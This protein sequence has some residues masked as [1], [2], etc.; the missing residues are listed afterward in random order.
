MNKFYLILVVLLTLTNTRIAA[1]VT[2][3]PT[4]VFFENNF[5]SMIIINTSNISQD[6]LVDFIFGYPISDSLGNV[7]M[8]YNRM[9]DLARYD[10]SGY[11][12]AFP[13]AITLDPGQRQ[14]VRLNIRPPNDLVES[15]YWT[16]IKVTSTPQIQDIAETDESGVQTQLNFIFEQIIPLYFRRGSVKTE[17]SLSDLSV[18]NAETSRNIVFPVVT[19]GNAPFLG[20][21]LLELRDVS[22]TLVH[23]D[24]QVTSL[25]QN[26]ARRF[27]LPE[28]VQP[29]EYNITV[30]FR[31]SRPDVPTSYHF[32]MEPTSISRKLTIN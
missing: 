17:L 26:G 22:N 28:T 30:T 19:T 14:T 21:I 8:S 20:T 23:S 9:G 29:G 32:P 6:V 5:A 4:S 12:R 10:I 2:I 7:V 16:R 3:S 18:I 11:V 25:F 13:R 31:S 27:T 1:Q 24:T 15:V